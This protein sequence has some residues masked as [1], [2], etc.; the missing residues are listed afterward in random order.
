M[1]KTKNH[2]SPVQVIR[3]Y[4]QRLHRFLKANQ[5]QSIILMFVAIGFLFVRSTAYFRSFSIGV[6]SVTFLI[7][8]LAVLMMKIPSLYSFLLALLTFWGAFL[9]EKKGLHFWAL[10]L[11]T[12]TYYFLAA[13]AIQYLWETFRAKL[14]SSHGKKE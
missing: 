14:K 11:A 13:G 2:L 1:T 7:W 6:R 5:T 4:S 9:L 12:Y 8:F 3:K 10:R